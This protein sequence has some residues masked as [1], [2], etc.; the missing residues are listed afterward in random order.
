MDAA[1]I[2]PFTNVV[3]S[4]DNFDQ[5]TGLDDTIMFKMSMKGGSWDNTP[6]QKVAWT[7]PSGT[8]LVLV[9]PNA[10]GKVETA[11]DLFGNV[12]HCGN[13]LCHDGF[14][15]LKYKCDTPQF[16]GNG[17]GYCDSRDVLFSRLR[18]LSG[19]PDDPNARFYTMAD[20]NPSLRFD[21]WKG[22]YY[23]VPLPN[24]I[25]DA[26]GNEA[27]YRGVI[28]L[29]WQKSGTGIVSVD[30]TIWDVWLLDESHGRDLDAEH[31]KR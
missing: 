25:M 28:N 16:G 21:L 7:R 12:T 11:D 19:R 10:E 6:L 2:G 23:F 27:R 29:G 22:S 17:D 30:R 4:G 15:A 3:G 8:M 18:W 26:H 20:I 14:E 24:R 5:F 9:L 1:G 13:A 31:H